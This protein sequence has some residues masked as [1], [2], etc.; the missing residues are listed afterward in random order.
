MLTLTLVAVVAVS[1]HTQSAA[2]AA[3]EAVFLFV[4]PGVVSHAK[5]DE[6]KVFVPPATKENANPLMHEGEVWEVR[7]DN[8]YA[9]TTW[10]AARKVFRMW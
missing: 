2:E 4:D 8:T 5:R 6:W 10:D 7:W 9:T 1:A 3:S